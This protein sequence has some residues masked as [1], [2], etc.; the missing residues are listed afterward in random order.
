MYRQ[1]Y[2]HHYQSHH[3]VIAVAMMCI[4][5]VHCESYM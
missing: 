2:P 5:Q 1:N 3:R 4:N